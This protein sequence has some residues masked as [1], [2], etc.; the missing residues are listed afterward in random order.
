MQ[1]ELLSYPA[2]K[3]YEASAGVRLWKPTDPAA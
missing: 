2:G 1:M 3:G